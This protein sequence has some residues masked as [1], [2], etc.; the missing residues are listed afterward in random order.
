MPAVKGRGGARRKPVAKH[1]DFH[2][3]KR[4][5][6]VDPYE[7]S[8]HEYLA[9]RG[10]VLVGRVSSFEVP[11]GSKECW[12]NDLW[13][14]KRHRK[15]GLGKELLKITIDNA[16]SQ[17]YERVMAELTPYDGTPL[18]AIERLCRDQGFDIVAEWEGAQKPVALLV[19]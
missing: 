10:E 7:R 6:H 1:L 11:P 12:I 18:A 13:V 9:F 17:G 4:V 2:I 5:H 16:R 8:W 14:E 19:L 15:A 3:V